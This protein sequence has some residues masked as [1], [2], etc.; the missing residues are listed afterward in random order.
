LLAAAEQVEIARLTQVVEAAADCLVL[1]VRQLALLSELAAL[2]AA[3]KAAQI[4]PEHL[5]Q[6]DLAVG[7]AGQAAETV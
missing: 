5:L 2:M 1:A 4:L 6:I 7:Q 3:H